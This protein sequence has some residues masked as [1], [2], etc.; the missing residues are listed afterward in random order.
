MRRLRAFVVHQ[1][2]D[3]DDQAEGGVHGEQR[4]TARHV[5]SRRDHLPNPGPDRRALNV[6]QRSAVLLGDVVA[7]H[8]VDVGQFG[9]GERPSHVGIDQLHYGVGGV[10]GVVDVRQDGRD[11]TRDPVC[12]TSIRGRQDGLLATEV[13]VDGRR[14]DA[15]RGGDVVHAGVT[16]SALVEE[17]QRH[18]Q[19]LLVLACRCAHLGTSRQLRPVAL[20][21]QLGVANARGHADE[22]VADVGLG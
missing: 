17:L 18:V 9:I 15:H 8:V 19:E 1:P 6:V 13:A 7:L 16:V 10:G 14:G 12:G 11:V 20:D 4:L 21:R 22:R 5:R 2:A 3:V